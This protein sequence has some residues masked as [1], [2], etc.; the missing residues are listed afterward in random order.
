MTGCAR[1]TR[2]SAAKAAPMRAADSPTAYAPSRRSTSPW[3]SRVA[4]SR[5]AVLRLR[6]HSAASAG[7]RRVARGH[8]R[9]RA[10]ERH[11][12][13]H[14]LDAPD[15]VGGLAGGG[16]VGGHGRRLAPRP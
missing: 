2:P 16:F 13:V 6:P 5:H 15:A 7:Q 1:R 3:S 10:Q 4:S 11:R 9:D 14:G 12:A 8:R